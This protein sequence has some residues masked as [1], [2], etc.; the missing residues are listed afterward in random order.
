[1]FKLLKKK[2]CSA[3][4]HIK[5][6]TIYVC[7]CVC[8]RNGCYVTCKGHNV[9]N[10]FT[11]YYRMV[12]AHRNHTHTLNVNSAFLGRTHRIQNIVMQSNKKKLWYEVADRISAPRTIPHTFLSA[13]KYCGV[14]AA[15]TK[16][17]T[18]KNMI[19]RNV[20]IK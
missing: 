17:R 13:Y 4:P 19:S 15:V 20:S 10:N 7:M 14:G 11:T 12:V 18:K 6:I 16:T 5:L 3:T 2:S 1:M 8:V 9:A